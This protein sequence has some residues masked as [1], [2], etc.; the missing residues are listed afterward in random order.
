[1]DFEHETVARFGHTENF[2][3]AEIYS[4]YEEWAERI[5]NGEALRIAAQ[6]CDFPP[7]WISIPEVIKKPLFNPS[8]KDYFPI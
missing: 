6:D 2:Y 1:M 3:V 7:L 5:D 4:V 8:E